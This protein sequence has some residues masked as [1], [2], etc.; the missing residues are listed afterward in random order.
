MTSIENIVGGR[1]NN[2][3]LY[4][5]I[6][7]EQLQMADSVREIVLIRDNMLEHH[8][9]VVCSHDEQNHLIHVVCTCFHSQFCICVYDFK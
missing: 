5:Q 9:D 8:N 4:Y 2:I 7:D 1:L 3:V 6:N